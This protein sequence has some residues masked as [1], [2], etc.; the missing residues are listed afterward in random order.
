VVGIER[1]VVVGGAWTEMLHDR[2]N[3]NRCDSDTQQN[4][5]MNKV[6]GRRLFTAH[7]LPY[8]RVHS[9][10]SRLV[11]PFIQQL[12][13]C[14]ATFDGRTTTSS[15]SVCQVA[16]SW[17]DVGSFHT[18]LFGVV[19]FAIALVREF[20]DTTSYTIHIGATGFLLDS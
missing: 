14:K 16:R 8:M 10:Y 2:R 17:V 15:E 11:L 1:S 9:K 5:H 7:I 3:S 12:W 18:R 4:T 20:L 13:Q 6:G 19:Y